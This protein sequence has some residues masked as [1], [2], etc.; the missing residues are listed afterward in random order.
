MSPAPGAV[1][2]ADKPVKFS[3]T[4]TYG[5]AYRVSS[6][7]PNLIPQASAAAVG[8]VG[9]APG[10][11]NS[12]DG[13]LNFDRGDRVA[14][15][16]KA[17]ANVDF[18]YSNFG[19]RVRAK[20]WHDFVNGDRGV[21]WGNLPNAYAPNAPLSDSGFDPLAQ[22]SGVALMDAYVEGRFSVGGGS[23]LARLGKQT[24]PW[25]L[26]GAT[27]R[28]GLDQINAYDIPA[29][30]RPGA[31]RDEWDIPALAAFARLELSPKVK[32]QGFYQL[33]FEPNQIPGCGTFNSHADYAAHG[34]DKVVVGPFNDRQAVAG[35]LFAKRAPDRDPSDSG[36]FGVGLSYLV[37]NVGLF[38]FYYANIHGRRWIPSAI[39][40]TRTGLPPL[41]PGDPGGGN[42]QYFTEY[43][44]D[45][46]IFGL[47][48][49]TRFE[50]STLGVELTHQPNHP[51]RLNGTDML[52]AFASNV[53]P[54]LLRAD[55]NATPPGAAYHGFDR[56]RIT[57]LNLGGTTPLAILPGA[58]TLNLAGEFGVKYV[59]DLPDPAVRRYGRADPFG[60]GPVN[61]ACV[62]TATQCSNDGFV[63]SVSWG[64]RL[65]VSLGLPQLVEGAV[66]TPSVSFLHDVRGW[67]HDEVFNGNR[68]AVRVA[69][70]GEYQKR[71]FAE[72]GWTTI[73]GG[74]YDVSR[75]RDTL[76]ISAGVKF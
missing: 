17:I 76:A 19:G 45:I 30:M 42:V 49:G 8:A 71:Y 32:L 5:T 40:S 47:T 48:F 56:L 13:N 27:I 43:P 62:G 57:Q 14:T 55:A 35:G 18:S 28:G 63:S 34:C 7:D 16:L 2:T 51:V 66:I 75:D 69:V 52:N 1:T 36:Q 68:K 67:S 22:F 9:R 33:K 73:W 44:D 11:Q 15:V 64:Y 54:T 37:D 61:G 74:T 70:L 41:I 29:E 72:L 31:I 59:H 46:R 10:G 65:R 23:L 53:L 24:I 20:A 60:L 6:R 12:D 39:K 38:G 50:N 4:V 26:P 3:G 21:P 25:G 58:H